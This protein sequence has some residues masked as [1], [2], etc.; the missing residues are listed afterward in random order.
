MSLYIGSQDYE[1][2]KQQYE[3]SV[4]QMRDTAQQQVSFQALGVW[5]MYK[6]YRPPSPLLPFAKGVDEASGRSSTVSIFQEPKLEDSRYSTEPIYARY[7]TLDF[8]FVIKVL[9][10]LFA[11]M[12][13]F[14]LINGESERG[15]L[16]LIMSNPVPRNELVLAKITGALCSLLVPL[17]IPILIGVGAVML[18]TQV[19]WDMEH[20]LRILIT[21]FSSILYISTFI[22]LGVLISTV[23][24]RPSNAFIVLVLFWVSFVW[25]IPRVGLFIST[26]VS[27][28]Q[29]PYEIDAQ[30]G[31]IDRQWYKESNEAQSQW[32]ISHPEFD[33]VPLD[34]QGKINGDLQKKAQKKKARVDES[35]KANR[36]YRYNLTQ[37]LSRISPSAAFENIILAMTMTDI[38]NQSFFLED[39]K[40]YRED[41]QQYVSQRMMAERKKL[42][43]GE[44]PGYTNGLNLSGMPV[45]TLKKST[46]VTDISRVTYDFISLLVYFLT[47]NILSYYA[48][49]RFSVS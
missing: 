34:I 14:D 44:D 33:T 11:L 39:V 8:L 1:R 46:L 27:E 40:L 36:E 41:F 21:I 29:A 6:V 18:S 26:S 48:F 19:S 47:F 12:L 45:L 20:W 31:Q 23:I 7:S 28:L 15:T 43:L 25:V 24:A 17:L 9:L 38:Q 32:L 35:Y 4:S 3:T 16:K 22:V 2:S 10:A 37:W 42:F 13:T 5:G 49:M 30:K